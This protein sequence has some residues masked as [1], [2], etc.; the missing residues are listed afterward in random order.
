[1]SGNR[2]HNRTKRI[3]VAEESD[4]DGIEISRNTSLSVRPPKPSSLCFD[5]RNKSTKKNVTLECSFALCSPALPGVY[6]SDDKRITTGGSSIQMPPS[7]NY[8]ITLQWNPPTTTPEVGTY[9]MAIV[10]QFKDIEI[11][12]RLEID[13]G[14][15][16]LD[17]LRPIT[18][19][20]GPTYGRVRTQRV[21]LKADRPEQ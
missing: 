18:P 12:R 5:I 14:D 8:K 17:Q 1:V 2:H 6:L 3:W 11:I 4:T 10:F 15:E 19:Y 9:K 21:I 7:T 13:V 16:Q 20:T